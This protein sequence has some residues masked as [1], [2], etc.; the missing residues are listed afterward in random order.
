MA[1]LASWGEF[2]CKYT[3]GWTPVSSNTLAA[4]ADYWRTLGMAAYFKDVL[5]DDESF[6]QAELPAFAPQ[7][8]DAEQAWIR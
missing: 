6:A 8:L 5:K 1:K 3:G 4:P 2:R 7:Q